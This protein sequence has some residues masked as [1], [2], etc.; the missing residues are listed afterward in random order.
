[1]NCSIARCVSIFIIFLSCHDFCR[2]DS[3]VA[4]GIRPHVDEGA[5]SVNCWLTPTN[6]RESVRDASSQ[7]AKVGG[8]RLY[9]GPGVEG[10]ARAS[11][12]Q[13]VFSASKESNNSSTSAVH[14]DSYEARRRA[15]QD[16]RSLVAVIEAAKARGTCEQV[17]IA[18]KQNRCVV[19]ESRLLHE[20]SPTLNFRS[21]YRRRR[22]N[23][24]F[25]FGNSL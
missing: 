15:N 24:T 23:L 22:I 21:G 1:M 10:E 4:Q 11:A 3:A 20:T 8:L 9:R 17:D 14:T 6:A 25:V 16:F 19:F 18:Y 2:Y 12:L 5:F 7:N 13:E